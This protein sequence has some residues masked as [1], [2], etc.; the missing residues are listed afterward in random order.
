MGG[1][2]TKQSAFFVRMVPLIRP[3]AERLNINEDYLLALCAHEHG[4]EDQHNDRLHNLFG[5]TKGGGNNLGFSSDHE[6]CDWWRAHYGAVV[7]SSSDMTDFIRR[8]RTIP[9]NSA[10][11]NYDQK[12]ADVYDAVVR[13]KASCGYARA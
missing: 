4:W 2:P 13:Y 5:V 6:A 1:C 9:Y 7:S 10:T 3:M 12:L 8:L 11:K